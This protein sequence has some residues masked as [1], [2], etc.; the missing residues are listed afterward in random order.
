[1]V[2]LRRTDIFDR[3]YERL[4]DPLARKRIA[5]RVERLAKGNPG[6]VRAVGQGVLELRLDYG[7]GYRIYFSRRGSSVAILLA[8]GDKSSQQR[9]IRRAIELARDL[10]GA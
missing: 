8:G 4:R 9:D 7:P 3:W 6:D 2:E 10:Q 5:D 1:M